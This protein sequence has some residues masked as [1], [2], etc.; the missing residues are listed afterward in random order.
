MSGSRSDVIERVY[1]AYADMLYRIALTYLHNRD[2]AEDAVH[3]AFITYMEK[4]PHFYSSKKER[5]WIC[6]VTVNLCRDALRRRTVRQHMSLDDDESMTVPAVSDR[7]PVELFDLLNRLPE[8]L[9]IVTVLHYLEGFSV[10]ETATMTASTVSAV[11]MRLSRARDS[12]KE[13]LGGDIK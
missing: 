7:Y 11:K 8:K 13:F 6:Q 9:R 4:A 1:G 3:D 2:D 10:S 12:L 5:A